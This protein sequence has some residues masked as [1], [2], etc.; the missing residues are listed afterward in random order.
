[1][2]PRSLLT[3]VGNTSLQLGGWPKLSDRQFPTAFARRRDKPLKRL[4]LFWSVPTRLKPGV[5]EIYLFLRRHLAR[6]WLEHVPDSFSKNLLAGCIWM[7][8]VG[9]IQ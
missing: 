7:N 1:M 6:Y 4:G 3:N 9:D 5:T 8:S 2:V